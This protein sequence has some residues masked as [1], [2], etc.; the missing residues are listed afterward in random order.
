MLR[1]IDEAHEFILQE[2]TKLTGEEVDETEQAILE[3]LFEDS[4]FEKIGDI[5]TEQEIEDQKLKTPEEFEWFLFHRVP[6]YMTLL[7][8]TAVEVLSN[9]LSEE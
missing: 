9:Y 1:S 7:E 4:F 5:V 2:V 6:N 8:E 3:D